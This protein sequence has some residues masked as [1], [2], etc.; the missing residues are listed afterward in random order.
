MY[1]GALEGSF[2]RDCGGNKGYAGISLCA[3]FLSFY[4]GDSPS[5]FFCYL[6]WFL[7]YPV[8][9]GNSSF[10]IL[11]YVIS[12]AQAWHMSL[13][14]YVMERRRTYVELFC[15]AALLLIITLNPCQEFI[16]IFLC[17]IFVCVKCRISDTIFSISRQVRKN[18]TFLIY[19][20]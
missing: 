16:H 1:E 13:T 9:D 4:I 12:Q 8:I 17:L 10:C 18:K 20:E 19:G 3:D 14:Q 11:L 5:D 15:Y 2:Q 6:F 7:I